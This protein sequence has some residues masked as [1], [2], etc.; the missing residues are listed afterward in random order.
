MWIHLLDRLRHETE[1]MNRAEFAALA[2]ERF[3]TRRDIFREYY[4]FDL[5]GSTEARLQWVAPTLKALE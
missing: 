1:P 2:V 5:V 4:N 3:A